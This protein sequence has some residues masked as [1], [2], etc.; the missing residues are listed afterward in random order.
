MLNLYSSTLVIFSFLQKPSL[1]NYTDVLP[2]N[3]NL[4]R[5]KLFLSWNIAFSLDQLM[6]YINAIIDHNCDDYGNDKDAPFTVIFCL[7]LPLGVSLSVL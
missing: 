3:I 6:F 5:K 4:F 1:E 7:K 2:V